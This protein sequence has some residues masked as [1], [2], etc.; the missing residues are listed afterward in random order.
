MTR[1]F[2]SIGLLVG[3]AAVVLPVVG[4]AAD[5]SQGAIQLVRS[6]EQDISAQRGKAAIEKLQ[7]AAD[8]APEWYV[9]PA[10]LATAYQICGM[11]TA[12]LQQYMRV[13]R[14]SL[15][16]YDPGSGFSSEVRQ[17]LAEAEGYMSL[18]VNR[19]R[20]QGGRR[21]LYTHP[22][23]A[24]VGRR[25]ALEMRDKDYFSHDS[26]T[27]SRRTIVDRFRLVFPFRPRVLGE[28]L[29]RRWRRGQGYTLSLAKIRNSYEDLLGSHG[30]RR[31]ILLPELTHLGIG[32]AV[33][34]KGDYWVS[35]IFADM[36]GHPEY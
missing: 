22:Q 31:T 1:R 13:Q 15:E 34:D 5:V 32:I 19:T 10:R 9:P 29:S 2:Q 7:Q 25:H 26:P 8:M 35:Q 6:A 28:N 30:H 21:L 3:L 20:R 27:P 18:L 36:T 17:L 24:V 23:M 33:N 14:I 12:A 4:P 16:R 11:E